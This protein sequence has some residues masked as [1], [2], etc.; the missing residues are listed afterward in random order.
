MSRHLYPWNHLAPLVVPSEVAV[1]RFLFDD[2]VDSENKVLSREWVLAYDLDPTALLALAIGSA[3]PTGYTRTI[4]GRRQQGTL[5][6]FVWR[7]SDANTRRAPG[8]APSME[9]PR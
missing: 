9:A 6:P 7:T 4:R 8:P 3:N 1:T 5:Y 2:L